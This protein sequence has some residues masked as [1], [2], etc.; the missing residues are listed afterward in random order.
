MEVVNEHVANS[1]KV[2]YMAIDFSRMSK[3]AKHG[4]SSGVSARN[5]TGAGTEWSS[6][7]QSLGNEILDNRV[8]KDYEKHPMDMSNVAKT[9]DVAAASNMSNV[10]SAPNRLDVLKELKNAAAWTISETSFFCK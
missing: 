9:T 1:A 8:Y 10:V 6:F 2:R 4:T 7:E 5:G 3:A